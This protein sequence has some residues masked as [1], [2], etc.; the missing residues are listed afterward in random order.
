METNRVNNWSVGPSSYLLNI[1]CI[2]CTKNI[3][4][5]CL[6]RLVE[7]HLT[8]HDYGPKGQECGHIL[9]DDLTL[10]VNRGGT[11]FTDKIYV[12]VL[13]STMEKN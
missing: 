2:K 9:F 8:N 7:S 5:D 4:P 12:N 1:Q 11:T 3:L 13:E 10:A 6:F